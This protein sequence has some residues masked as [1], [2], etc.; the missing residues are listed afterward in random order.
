ML[1]PDLGTAI[2]TVAIVLGHALH[3]G[4]LRSRPLGLAT[5]VMAGA[6]TF[7]T[8]SAPY[9]RARLLPSSTP[10]TTR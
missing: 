7:L 6:A 10:R 2:V 4:T 3:R 1:Q 5:A 9:R 8:M